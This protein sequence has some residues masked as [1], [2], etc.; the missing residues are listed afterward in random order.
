MM[1][2]RFVR[3]PSA[4]RAYWSWRR[5]LAAEANLVRP[6]PTSEL[7]ESTQSASRSAKLFGFYA[8]VSELSKVLIDKKLPACSRSPQSRRSDSPQNGPLFF[9]SDPRRPGESPDHQ[10][11]HPD[12][13][14][15]DIA[16][17]KR[18]LCFAKIPCALKIVRFPATMAASSRSSLHPRTPRIC[19]GEPERYTC[20]YKGS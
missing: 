13:T 9:D 20:I 10:F 3:P 5:S 1:R 4:R 11:R 15:T 19:A 8:N 18:R 12:E 17:T 6:E 16:P 7:L 14:K 2:G